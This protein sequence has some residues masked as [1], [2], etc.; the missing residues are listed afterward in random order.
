MSRL[1]IYIGRFAV[2]L[3]G[4]GVAAL[5]ASA[6]LHLM[7]LAAAGLQP[8]EAP[9][10]FLHSLAFSIPFV[11][12]FVSYFAF[13]PAGA[14]IIVSEVLGLKSWLFHALAGAAVGLAVAALF[15]QSPMAFETVGELSEPTL[16]T[17]RFVASLIGSGI[18]GGLAYWLC[19]GRSAGD[20]FA[21][22]GSRRDKPTSSGP[23][24]S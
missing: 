11:A 19:A 4:Y 20:W 6:F 16:E 21:A 7:A 13:L 3:V 14:A 10:L 12:L 8:G 18:V 5:A 1:L 9:P 17:P 15:W 22:A 24:G 2:I 23:S